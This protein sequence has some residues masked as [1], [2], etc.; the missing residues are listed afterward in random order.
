M[1]VPDK[2]ALEPDQLHGLAVQSP[3]NPGIPVI[4]EQHEFFRQGYFFNRHYRWL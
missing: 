2:L 3:G 4:R 1:P